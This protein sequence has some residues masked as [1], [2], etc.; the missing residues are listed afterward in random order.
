MAASPVRTPSTHEP[1]ERPEPLPA[2]QLDFKDASTMSADPDGGKRQH[3]GKIHN[4]VDTGTRGL[5]FG[6]PREK[7]CKYVQCVRIQCA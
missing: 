1:P 6:L 5:A 7:P 4:T 2:W 3:V